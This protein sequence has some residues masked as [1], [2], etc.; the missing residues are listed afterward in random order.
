[1]QLFNNSHYYSVYTRTINNV[2]D[3]DSFAAESSKR[4]QLQQ[5]LYWEQKDC[6]KHFG[7]AFFITFTYNDSNS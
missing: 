6:E 1:M 2:P 7:Q 5:R 3:N 4:V